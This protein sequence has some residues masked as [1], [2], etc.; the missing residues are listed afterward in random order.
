[1]PTASSSLRPTVRHSPT[2]VDAGHDLAPGEP[3]LWQGRPTWFGAARRILRGDLVLGYFALL[4]AIGGV[5]AAAGWTPFASLWGVLPPAL[6]VGAI[7]AALAH[8]IVRTT[9]YLVT[10]RRIVIRYGAAVPR[11]LS[12]P[13]S[14]IASLS[15]AVREGGRGDIVIRMRDTTTLRYLKLWPHVRPFHVAAPQPML[16]DVA[17]A[18]VIAT[19]LTRL[20]IDAEERRLPDQPATPMAKRAY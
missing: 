18:G 11:S 1:M 4:L 16:R 9:H 13:F 7:I 20:L 10:P 3:I 19:R 2:R 8:A 14:Q 5:R 6:L 15:V 17:D 12:L